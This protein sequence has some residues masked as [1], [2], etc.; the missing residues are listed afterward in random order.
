LRYEDEDLEE[1]E[2]FYDFSKDYEVGEDGKII[3][4]KGYAYLSYQ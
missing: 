2:D 1:Y 3:N 4:V